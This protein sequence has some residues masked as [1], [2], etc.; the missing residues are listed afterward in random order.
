M[1]P[2]LGAR[3]SKGQA[4]AADKAVQDSGPTA[5]SRPMSEGEHKGLTAATS[6]T[7]AAVRTPTWAAAPRGAGKVAE[8]ALIAVSMGPPSPKRIPL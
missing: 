4:L 6:L 8:G 3:G 2:G 1:L 7:L 5:P